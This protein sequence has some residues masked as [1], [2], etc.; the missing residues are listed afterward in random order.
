[1]HQWLDRGDKKVVNEQGSTAGKREKQAE[2]SAKTKTAIPCRVRSNIAVACL[3]MQ[4]AKH[5]GRNGKTGLLPPPA[6]A[7]CPPPQHLLHGAADLHLLAG[8][9]GAA[10]VDGR[11]HLFQRG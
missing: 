6:P 4:V 11:R 10:A 8:A 1:M 2:E 7:A 3:G 9:R 5:E